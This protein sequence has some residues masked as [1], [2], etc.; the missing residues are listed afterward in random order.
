MA[1]GQRGTVSFQRQADGGAKNVLKLRNGGGWAL[2]VCSAVKKVPGASLVVRCLRT[3]LAGQGTQV[4]CLV[5]ELR[6]HMQCPRATT[7]AAKTQ[8][9]QIN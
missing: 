3:C 5:G 6:S 2:F 9:S 7:K 4:Q 8:R 1:A